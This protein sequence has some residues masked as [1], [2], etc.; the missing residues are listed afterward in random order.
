[1]PKM[2]RI[3]CSGTPY[4]IGLQHGQEARVQISRSIMFYADLFQR[5]CNLSWEAVQ[6]LAMRDFLPVIQEKWPE[7]MQEM[8][9]I[10]DGTDLGVEDILALNVRTEV[11]FG[12]F[13][14]GCTAFSTFGSEGGKGD[15][16]W[17]SQNW[18][19]NP[20]QKRNLVQ[21]SITQPGK[22]RIM[23]ITEAGIIGKIG[24]NEYG[25]GVCLNAIRAS[26]VDFRKLPCH[27]GLRV[28]LESASREDALKRLEGFGGVASACHMLIADREGGVGVEWSFKGWEKIE[29]DGKGRVFHAN[30][31]LRSPAEGVKEDEAWLEGS[32]Y[33]TKRIEE[34][35][36]RLQEE[37]G[38]EVSYEGILEVFKDEGGFP[39]SICRKREGDSTDETLF[40]IVMDLKGLK[41]FV[42]VG[43]PTEPE[44]KLE[45]VF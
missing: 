43:R 42:V 3:E 12:M 34:L 4:E 24:M 18:D 21:L 17:L 35:V 16:S 26:G 15:V 37:H 41:A 2:L 6:G 19:W 22:P 20:L 44:E 11:A 33:R 39:K 31:Y 8:R 36:D 32:R 45:L 10:A 30:H 28:V 1:M 40:N 9:G 23:M 27:L 5:N 25:V 14:D 29:M 13:S 7:L 38:G